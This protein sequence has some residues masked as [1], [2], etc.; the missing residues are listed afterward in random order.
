MQV[1][2]FWTQGCTDSGQV[3]NEEGWRR[4]KFVGGSLERR[5]VSFQG[6]C[7]VVRNASGSAL[8]SFA[9]SE[10]DLQAAHATGPL[11]LLA[12]S[13]VGSSCSGSL[14]FE[15]LASTLADCEFAAETLKL[16]V[17]AFQSF[18]FL[19]A[20]D[21]AQLLVLCL[22]SFPCSVSSCV[23]FGQASD[24]LHDVTTTLGAE[25]VETSHAFVV[26]AGSFEGFVLL[27]AS[28]EMGSFVLALACFESGTSSFCA[29]S[30]FGK[31]FGQVG[32]LFGASLCSERKAHRYSKGTETQQNS[33]HHVL[34]L[35]IIGKWGHCWCGIIVRQIRVLTL[36]TKWSDQYSILCS[37][38]HATAS[39]CV[40]GK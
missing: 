22:A 12:T 13:F 1:S 17:E 18:A 30:C 20:L 32:A 7:L 10:L 14:T 29:S 33:L 23:S 24:T 36:R 5:N 3:L 38:F 37:A 27:A 26:L 2:R 11:V 19:A 25:T 9:S 35:R 39:H 16:F 4:E 6:V 21:K 31:S 8:G 15:K 40:T 28:Q 34:L